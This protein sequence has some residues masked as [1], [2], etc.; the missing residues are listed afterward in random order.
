MATGYA[1]ASLPSF[2]ES[3]THDLT[4]ALLQPSRWRERLTTI[5]GVAINIGVLAALVLKLRAMPS[6]E[7][8]IVLPASPGFWALLLS[9]FLAAPAIDWLILRRLWRL[10]VAGFGALLRKQ[11]ANELF[12]GYSGDAHF[13]LWARASLPLRKAPFATLRDMSIMSALAGNF[14]TLLLMAAAWPWFAALS[15]GQLLRDAAI[16]VLAIVASSLGIFAARR[17]FFTFALSR[18][19]LLAI[20]LAYLG[21][22]ALSLT[23]CTML[24]ATLLPAVAVSTLLIL[25]ALRAMIS[26]LPLL[27][28]KDA[29]FAGAVLAFTG[30]AGI[31]GATATVALLTI[32]LYAMVAIVGTAR[33]LAA[34]RAR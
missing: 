20:F 10:P 25:A 3:G 28:G 11:T 1:P 24:W 29:L 6:S 19:A 15:G 31:A 17:L 4:A 9:S 12:L 22:I 34:R 2:D 33:D 13:Y 26:R 21:R 14:A 23:L 16:A 7:A 32:M 18:R 30:H 27:P 8:S 5:A